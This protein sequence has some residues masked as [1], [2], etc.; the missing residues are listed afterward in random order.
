MIL[1]KIPP[2]SSCVLIYVNDFFNPTIIVI[3]TYSQLKKERMKGKTV[4][5]V[6]S[7]HDCGV[8]I[9]PFST[10]EKAE[11]EFNSMLLRDY[12]E[13]EIEENGWDGETDID[14]EDG[15]GLRLEQETI[16]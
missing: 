3:F 8:D 5:L 13:E 7:Q 16:N 14:F 4:Y 1:V 12:D 2:R 15:T 11:N 6:V 9:T 10:Y